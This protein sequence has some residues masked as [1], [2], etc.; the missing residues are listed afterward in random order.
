MENQILRLIPTE[1]LLAERAADYYQRNR[2][3]LK[4]FEPVREERFFT[5]DGQREILEQ[6]LQDWNEARAYRFYIQPAENPQRIIGVIGL[7]NVVWGGVSFRV[8]GV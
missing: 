6:E 8:P 7:N 3:F 1:P 4:D 2:A 5:A